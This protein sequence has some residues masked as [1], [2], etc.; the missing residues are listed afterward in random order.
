[1]KFTLA[2]LLTSGLLMA[3]GAMAAPATNDEPSGFPVAPA[4]VDPPAQYI[5]LPKE[6]RVNATEIFGS[7]LDDLKGL[8]T[9]QTG[10]RSSRITACS[11]SHRSG[12]C[13]NWGQQGHCWDFRDPQLSP[14]NDALSSVYPQEQGIEWTLWE[15]VLTRPLYAF[16]HRLANAQSLS[17][18]LQA[19]RMQ[20]KRSQGLGCCRR[21]PRLQLQ[22]R[23]QCFFMEN[24][25]IGIHCYIALRSCSQ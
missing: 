25:V 16:Y 9:R 8:E 2:T 24:P 13:I 1:M 21:P 10:T 19:L 5:P 7:Y 23:N 17:P 4:T 14:Y 11:G 12:Q 20:R 6:Q 3:P 22:R 15:Y 18:S